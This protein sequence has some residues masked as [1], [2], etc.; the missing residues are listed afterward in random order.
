MENVVW[1]M[2]AILSRPQCVKMQALFISNW[3]S[4]IHGLRINWKARFLNYSDVV[5][6]AIASQIT[7][8]T[9][10]YSTVCS[11]A[12]EI[13][14]QSSASLAFVRGIHRWPVNSPHK[15]PFTPKKFPFEDVIILMKQRSFALKKHT[16]VKSIQQCP[17]VD[18]KN[19]LKCQFWIIIF[20]DFCLHISRS[21]CEIALGWMSMI[22][23]QYWLR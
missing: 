12:D 23:C 9:I 13:L 22:S 2:A 21:F 10:V 7:S 6:S 17:L 16:G 20:D 5:I 18:T 14:H 1:K 8:L 19:F 15:G 4:F 3:I 11:G